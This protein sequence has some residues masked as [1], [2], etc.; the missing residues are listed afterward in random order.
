[1]KLSVTDYMPHSMVVRLGNNTIQISVKKLSSLHKLSKVPSEC[2][3]QS[4]YRKAG[5]SILRITRE[6]KN[7]KYKT[8]IWI[9]AKRI[10]QWSYGKIKKKSTLP[11]T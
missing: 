4:D 6:K 5:W 8:K 1:M 11:H 10:Y 9:C 2:I 3:S 7:T